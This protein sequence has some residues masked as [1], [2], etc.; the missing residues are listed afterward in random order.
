MKEEKDKTCAHYAKSAAPL[1]AERDAKPHHRERRMQQVRSSRLDPGVR[2]REPVSLP[3]CCVL[4]L[5]PD[6]GWRQRRWT[7]WFGLVRWILYAGD[8]LEG[9]LSTHDGA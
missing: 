5:M 9:D 7:A 8:V 4:A 3:E 6:P 2:L 1:T